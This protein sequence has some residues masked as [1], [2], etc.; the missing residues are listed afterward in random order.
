M[1]DIEK[2]ATPDVGKARRELNAASGAASGGASRQAAKD[3][4][5]LPSGSDPQAQSLGLLARGRRTIASAPLT[6]V[7]IAAAIAA[8]LAFLFGAYVGT[9]L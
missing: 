9:K 5:G 2:K 7:L 6:Y 1:S 4:R 8:G 3:E